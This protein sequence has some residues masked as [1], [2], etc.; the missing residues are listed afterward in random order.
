MSDDEGSSSWSDDDVLSIDAELAAASSHHMSAEE[1]EEEEEELGGSKPAS[2][3]KH[4]PA[5]K[6]APASSPS[7][8]TKKTKA[9]KAEKPP[10]KKKVKVQEPELAD[11]EGDDDEDEEGWKSS[12][13]ALALYDH[14]LAA[15]GEARLADD[16]AVQNRDLKQRMYDAGYP[17]NSVN[18]VKMAWPKKYEEG[19]KYH[20]KYDLAAYIVNKGQLRIKDEEKLA[21]KKAQLELELSVLTEEEKKAYEKAYEE[22][23]EYYVKEVKRV[24]DEAEKW[25]KDSKNA[26]LMKEVNDSKASTKVKKELEKKEKGGKGSR[27]KAAKTQQPEIPG[28]VTPKVASLFKNSLAMQAE[29]DEDFVKYQEQQQANWQAFRR[30][31]FTKINRFQQSICDQGGEM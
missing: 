2:S 11:L 28:H 5:K 16:D 23:H 3:K 14:E 12:T 29:I 30:A 25:K 10:A 1:E 13:A 7:S 8:K 15:V 31:T 27:K 19:H 24:N 21:K 20:E 18:N 22:A 26:E 4:T 9:P 17:K 6:K